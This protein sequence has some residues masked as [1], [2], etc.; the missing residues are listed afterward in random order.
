MMSS[1]SAA[2]LQ[3]MSNGTFF[4]INWRV[5]VKNCGRWS[6]WLFADIKRLFLCHELKNVPLCVTAIKPPNDTAKWESVN[7][8]ELPEALN[9]LVP[10]SCAALRAANGTENDSPHLLDVAAVDVTLSPHKMG[11]G[12]RSVPLLLNPS[13]HTHTIAEGVWQHTRPCE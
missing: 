11:A 12:R 13:A 4:P 6:S 10:H 8:F 7:E 5:K 2:S 9:A 3:L 1:S